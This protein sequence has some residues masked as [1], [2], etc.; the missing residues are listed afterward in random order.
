MTEIKDLRDG[1]RKVDVEATIVS[2][3]GPKSVN[4]RNGKKDVY[5][6]VLNDGSGDIKMTLWDSD[7]GT[8]KGAKVHISNGYVSSYN[9]NPQLNV[10]Q[11]GRLEVLGMSDLAATHAP[12]KPNDPRQGTVTITTGATGFSPEQEKRIREILHEELYGKA[13]A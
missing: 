13:D 5:N 2:F 7:M 10:G 4:T 3:E 11:Y 6:L 1:M 9:G 12:A 8:S